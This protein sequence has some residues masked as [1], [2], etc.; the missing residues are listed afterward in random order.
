VL[1][2]STSGGARR[3]LQTLRLVFEFNDAFQLGSE[4]ILDQTGAEALAPRRRHV[5]G[6]QPL[7]W[8]PLLRHA[9]GR[10]G[11]RQGDPRVTRFLPHRDARRGEIRV[12]EVADGNG[13]V[14]TKAFALPIYG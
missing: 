4:H 7:V 8:S 6:R 11:G 2:Q 3:A 12:G 1:L 10:R 5:V 9:L 13:D 14:S